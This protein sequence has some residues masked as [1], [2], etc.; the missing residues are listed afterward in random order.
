M[1][2]E[3]VREQGNLRH[4]CIPT[5]GQAGPPK[6]DDTTRDRIPCLIT[7]LFALSPWAHISIG[8]SELPEK[9]VLRRWGWETVFG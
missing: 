8:K 6:A 9:H 2:R 4:W 1:N 3:D 5:E 7:P